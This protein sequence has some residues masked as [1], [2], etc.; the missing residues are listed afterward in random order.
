MG[1]LETAVKYDEPYVEYK[2]KKLSMAL[3]SGGLPGSKFGVGKTEVTYALLNSDA[4]D[5]KCSFNI[6]VKDTLA[7]LISCNQDVTAQCLQGQSTAPVEYVTPIAAD[8]GLN[9]TPKLISGLKSGD[10]FPVG[11]TLVKYE[12]IDASGNRSVCS[13]KVIVEAA[14]AAVVKE[15]PVVT[16]NEPVMPKKEAPKAVK[17]EPAPTVKKD[18]PVPTKS[19]PIPVSKKEEPVPS[20]KDV[21]VAPK[22][23][24][25]KTK[26]DVVK[27]SGKS[28]IDV[29]CAPDVAKVNEPGKCG[30][31]INYEAPKIYGDNAVLRQTHGLSSGTFFPVGT[32]VNTYKGEDGMHYSKD[33]SFNV[34]VS[35]T[36]KPVM[37]CPGDSVIILSHNRQGVIFNYEPP[38]ARDNCGISDSIARVKGSKVGCFLPVGVHPFIFEAQDSSGN[39]QICSF[40]VTVKTTEEE[41]KIEAPKKLNKMLNMGNDSIHYEHKGEVSNCLLTIYMYDDGEEDGDSVSIVFD[42]QILVNRQLIRNKENGVIKRQ[43]V[44]IGGYDNYLIAKAWNT[45]RTGLNTLKIDIYEGYIE[46][47]KKDLKNKK[48]IISKILHSKPGDASGIMLKCKW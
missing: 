42:D 34:K 28:T 35:D 1:S 14:P 18:E 38:F 6:F 4:G 19:E 12:A 27:A 32:T 21:A 45:G 10:K 20:K 7:P 37:T 33:C 39:K 46:N 41:E 24:E 43:L 17:A 9:L 31:V 8:G 3:K 16:K 22:K 36:E 13:F 47:D 5:I 48:P 2:G 11:T 26:T 40:T 23:E 29:M 15:E 30:A 44:L 25:P